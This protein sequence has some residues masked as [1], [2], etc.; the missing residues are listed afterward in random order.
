MI[1]TLNLLACI[2]CAVAIASPASLSAL[3][4]TADEAAVNKRV[5]SVYQSLA[6]GDIKTYLAAF[7]PN[8]VR[9]V[10]ATVVVGRAAIEKAVTA[11]LAKGSVAIKFTRHATWLASPTTAIV[12]GMT[13]DTSVKPATRGHS[14]FTLVKEGNDWLVAAIQTAPAPPQ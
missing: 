4:Q 10:G 1:R 14:T 9:A 12:H 2:S 11:Q 8:A 3:G 6:T 5:E 7:H 13:E